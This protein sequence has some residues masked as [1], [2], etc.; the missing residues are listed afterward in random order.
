MCACPIYAHPK[1]KNALILPNL[2]NCTCDPSI[3]CAIALHWMILL[4]ITSCL[5]LQQGSS[6]IFCCFALLLFLNLFVYWQG[7]EAGV[8]Q[9]GKG[10]VS[11]TWIL[12][13]ALLEPADEGAEVAGA[14]QDTCI[15]VATLGHPQCIDSQI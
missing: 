2:G 14:G 8:H 1:F 9:D 3:C 4:F 15:G 5:A 10:L 6:T 13:R 11:S 12:G 7:R